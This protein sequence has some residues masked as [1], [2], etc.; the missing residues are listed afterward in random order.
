MPAVDN[1][2]NTIKEVIE[3]FKK[4]FEDVIAM[5]KTTEGENA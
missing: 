4:F 3:A 5:F 1:I 2:L